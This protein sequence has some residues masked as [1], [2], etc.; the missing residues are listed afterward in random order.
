MLHA[1]LSGIISLL[2]TRRA[3]I[4][5]LITGGGGGRLTWDCTVFYHDLFQV[6][7]QIQALLLS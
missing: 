7:P 2:A 5:G 3:D 1:I 4:Q 6:S